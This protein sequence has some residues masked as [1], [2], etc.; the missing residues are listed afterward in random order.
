MCGRDPVEEKGAVVPAGALTLKSVYKQ[1][2]E[3][4][5][6]RYIPCELVKTHYIGSRGSCYAR[7]SL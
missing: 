7:Q 2:W 6:E 4:R 3:W 5:I 1:E